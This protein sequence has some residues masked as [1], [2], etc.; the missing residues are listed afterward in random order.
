MKPAAGFFGD[1]LF[2]CMHWRPRQRRHQSTRRCP[3]QQQLATAKGKLMD[4]GSFLAGM[5]VGALC[6][7]VYGLFIAR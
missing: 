7:A 2:Q 6:L 5:I 4:L 1:E 3:P